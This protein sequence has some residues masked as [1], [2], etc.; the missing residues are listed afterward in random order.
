MNNRCQVTKYVHGQRQGD[1]S[2]RTDLWSNAAPIIERDNVPSGTAQLA[3][4][5]LADATA[6]D[7]LA[8]CLCQDFT[9]NFVARFRNDA[10]EITVKEIHAWI[11][12][13]PARDTAPLDEHPG[14]F[15]SEHSEDE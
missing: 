8:L 1:L 6:D 15:E 14:P 5:L 7:H 10:F 9:R 12:G 4:A 13:A 11:A 2:P 3:L